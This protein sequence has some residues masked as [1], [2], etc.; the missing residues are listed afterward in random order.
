MKTCS[1]CGELKPLETGF[2]KATRHRD[3]HQSQCKACHLGKVNFANRQNR[4]P[5]KI[6]ISRRGYRTCTTCQ[7][8]KP[9]TLKNFYYRA[10][11][12]KFRAKCIECHR[13]RANPG[14]V[15]L[16]ERDK[17][18]QKNKHRFD[19]ER[20]DCARRETCLDFVTR[21]GSRYLCVPCKGCGGYQKKTLDITEYLMN[22]KEVTRQYGSTGL[23]T[24]F[25]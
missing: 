22:Y 24:A 11:T 17:N 18:K 23:N 4:P 15:K 6:V 1:N 3:G 25:I 19:P 7:K 8:E 5:K 21:T 16:S 10:D 12:E 14:Y 13:R 2:Y 9:E 20:D